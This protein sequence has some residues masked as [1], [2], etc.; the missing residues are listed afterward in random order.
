MSDATRYNDDL[1]EHLSSAKALLDFG[2]AMPAHKDLHSIKFP[3]DAV[4]TVM[5]LFTKAHVTFRAIIILCEQGL[6]RPATALNRSLFETLTNLAFL[7]RQKVTLYRFNDN[8]AKPRTPVPLHGKALTAE[9]RLALFN[10]WSVLRDEKALDGWK[11]TPGLKRQGH[12][13][14]KRVQPFER[15]YVD[16]I[17]SDWEKSIRSQNT[18]VGL[19]IADFAASLGPIFRRW[20]RSVYAGDSSFIH[21]SDTMSYLAVTDD[22]NFSPRIFT[23]AQVVSGVLLRAATLYLGC[24]EELNKRFR[25]GPDAAA[26]IKEFGERLR[27]W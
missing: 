12:Q 16:A 6:E 23:S 27:N 14:A 5:A 22:G 1:P 3:R 20:H 25:F 15:A 2:M 13:I 19:S 4:V 9:L 7:V 10:A 26:K 21:Q 8:K 17:G 11:R 18:C 24:G